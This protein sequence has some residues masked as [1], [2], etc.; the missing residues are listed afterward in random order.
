M[1]PSQ[2]LVEYVRQILVCQRKDTQRQQ[3][4]RDALDQLDR[5][6]EI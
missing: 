5:G 1:N 4:E 6:D 3:Q 2:K